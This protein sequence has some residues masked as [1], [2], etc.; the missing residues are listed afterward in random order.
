MIG[1]CSRF[2][3]ECDRANDMGE[4]TQS[5]CTRSFVRVTQP[6]RVCKC[7]L[8]GTAFT[9]QED[10]MVCYSCKGVWKKLKGL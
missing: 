9:S 2:S 7:I 1:F 8:C 5:A 3:I 10:D 6:L 4:C